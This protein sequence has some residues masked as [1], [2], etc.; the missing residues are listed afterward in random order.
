MTVKAFWDENPNPTGDEIK[1]ALSG[2]FCRCISHYEV[3]K[4][5]SAVI[6]GGKNG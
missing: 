2:N 1:A 6:K 3:L 5:V 4:A